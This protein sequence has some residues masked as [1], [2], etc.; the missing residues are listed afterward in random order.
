MQQQPFEADVIAAF[1][2]HVLVRD[3]AGVTHKA[4]PFGRS[5]ALVCGDRVRCEHDARHGEIHVVQTLPRRTALYRSSRRGEAE[6]VCANLSLLIVVCA[7]RPAADLFVVDRYLAA[8]A[9]AGI[10]AQLVLNKSDLGIEADLRR[11]LDEYARLGLATLACSVRESQ[12]LDAL[13]A[14]CQGHTA[15]LVGQSGVGKSSLVRRL[16]PGADAAI[17]ELVREA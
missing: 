17:G 14:S 15:V 13:L 7:P 6:A 16:V 4:R 1:G 12:G 8:A 9:S 3:A 2:R 5:V 10:G 11:E